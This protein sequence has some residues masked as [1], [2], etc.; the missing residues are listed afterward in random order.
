MKK[1]KSITRSPN[2]KMITLKNNKNKYLINFTLSDERKIFW[3]NY[4]LK[5]NNDK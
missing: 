1:K 5:K 3:L 4:G 2:K